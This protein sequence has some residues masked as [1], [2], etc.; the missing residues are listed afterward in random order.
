[1]SSLAGISFLAKV[2]LHSIS[3]QFERQIRL[4]NNHG[5]QGCQVSVIEDEEL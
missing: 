4:A 3:A 2:L 1:M 5:S